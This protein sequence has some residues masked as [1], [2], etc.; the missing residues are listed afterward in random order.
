MKVDA[1]QRFDL[2]LRV[3]AGR[4]EPFG[5]RLLIIVTQGVQ[6]APVLQMQ[7]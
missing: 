1:H 2:P 6:I 5:D 7:Q 4:P 3:S